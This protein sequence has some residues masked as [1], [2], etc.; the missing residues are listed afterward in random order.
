ME[1]KETNEVIVPVTEKGKY[2]ILKSKLNE[3]P[4]Q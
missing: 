2:A 4:G 1:E 3:L